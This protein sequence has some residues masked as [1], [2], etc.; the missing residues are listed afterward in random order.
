MNFNETC[1]LGITHGGKNG[2]FFEYGKVRVPLSKSIVLQG[3]F[4]GSGD[5]EETTTIK[6]FP[7]INGY[8]T[9]DSPELPVT[10]GIKLF[11]KAT[12]EQAKW[13]AALTESW[14]EAVKNKETEVNAKIEMAGNECFEE[15]GC[16]ST[17][18]LL[19]RKGPAFKLPLKVKITAPWLEK[20]GSEPCYIGSDEHP[21][22]INLTTEGA[23][24]PGH[25]SFN[26]E[27]S[28]IELNDSRLVDTK[29]QIEPESEPTG[30]GGPYQSYLLAS[31]KH[32]LELPS[33]RTGIVVLQGDLFTSETF[34]V[35]EYGVPSG[36][37]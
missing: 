37:L 10:G 17:F 25:L 9:L 16:I 5:N 13:P 12:Q 26:E 1:Y 7:A 14:E 22:R 34:E 6:V 21:I 8:E 33:E 20:L 36:E 24:A 4:E 31:L 29:W 15:K 32:V 2:G 23:G 35:E 11:D 28:Q 30:C 19:V 3:G 27:F 18:N